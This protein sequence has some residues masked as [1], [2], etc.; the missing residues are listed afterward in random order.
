MEMVGKGLANVVRV[1]EGALPKT[2]FD[3]YA[4][5]VEAILINP[6]W[7]TSGKKPARPD[8]TITVE[9]FAQF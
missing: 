8:G 1:K 5:D 7:N 6:S 9:E 3:Q 4:K 2:N